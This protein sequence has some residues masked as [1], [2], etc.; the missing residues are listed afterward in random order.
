MTEAPSL[1]THQRS[2]RRAQVLTTASGLPSPPTQA[3]VLPL[4][5][6][7]HRRAQSA[8]ALVPPVFGD[9]H[10]GG[11]KGTMKRVVSR[12]KE[13]KDNAK[14]A[15]RRRRGVPVEPHANGG[16]GRSQSFSSSASTSSSSRFIPL[17]ATIS[18]PISTAPPTQPTTSD[19]ASTL[20]PGDAPAPS[21]APSSTPVDPVVPVLL[22]AGTP[23][24]KVSGKKQQRIVFKLDP[25]QGQVVWET[26]KIHLSEY[27]YLGLWLILGWYEQRVEP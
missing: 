13:L 12:G 21:I 26:K 20:L 25:D 6:A 1:L 5:P 3:H 4:R 9:P 16:H 7:A 19:P 27:P 8:G 11:I 24:T 10:I 17:M 2:L 22:Q 15:V 23:L 14:E 18:S